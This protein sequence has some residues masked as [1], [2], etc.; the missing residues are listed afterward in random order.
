[1]R[2]D[3]LTRR[4]AAAPR[5][6]VLGLVALSALISPGFVRVSR[7]SAHGLEP[8]RAVASPSARETA[9]L[10]LACADGVYSARCARLVAQLTDALERDA[11]TFASVRSLAN[12]RVVRGERGA[13]RLEPLAATGFDSIEAQRLLHARVRADVALERRFVAASGRET[14]LYAELAPGRSASAARAVV[15]S[16]RSELGAA[17]GAS[18]TL[19]GV[20]QRDSARAVLVAVALALGALAFGLAPG[21]WRVAVLAGLGAFALAAFAHAQLGLLGASGPALPGELPALLVACALSSSFVLIQRSRAEHRRERAP[22][23]SVASAL[24][25]VGPELALVALVSVSGFAALLAC[26]PGASLSLAL[27]AGSALAAALV[28]YPLGIA[29]AG[30]VSWPGALSR[31]RGELASVIARRAEQFLVRPRAVV[32]GALAGLSLTACALAALA[33]DPRAVELRTAVLDSGERGGALEPAFLERVAAFQRE[34]EARPGV[35]WTGSLVDTVF[36]PANRALHDGDPLFATVPLTRVEVERALE[37]WLRDPR[38]PLEPALDAE[39]RRLAVELYVVPSRVASAPVAS[40]ALA[41]SALAVALVAALSACVLRSARGGWLCA[42]PAALTA[43]LVLALASAFAGG[44]RGAS[45]SLAPI[46]A[47]LAAGL[48]LQWL[49]RV[50]ALLELGAQL[51]VSLSLSVREMGPSL[52]SAALASAAAVAALG[53]SAQAPAIHVAL[54]ALSPL[55]GAASALALLPPLVRALGGRFFASRVALRADVSA[56]DRL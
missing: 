23:S 5:W 55:L 35:V 42:A 52:A 24:A 11:E 44:F 13:L 43:A 29:L 1:M 8:L 48:G 45:A 22:R 51:E 33:P 56:V 36:A 15:E 19:L 54:A 25:V 26:A 41:S 6:V 18:L 20:G 46:A 47:A 16:L 49:L 7:D 50:R 37:P 28:A 53:A 2:F 39:Q 10:E 34:T 4:M 17:S 32:W 40:H 21:G 27:G 9:V 38:A 3:R 12:A 14:F 31:A 30:L